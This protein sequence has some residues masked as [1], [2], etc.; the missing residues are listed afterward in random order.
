[1]NAIFEL[2]TVGN[3]LL[4]GL[5]LYYQVAA[6]SML[7]FTIP[8]SLRL[9]VKRPYIL[10]SRMAIHIATIYVWYLLFKTRSSNPHQSPPWAL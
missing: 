7:F 1:M 3:T 10:N 8:E 2:R 9:I 6:L 5:I 4:V